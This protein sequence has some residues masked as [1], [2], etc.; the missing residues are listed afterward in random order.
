MVHTVNCCVQLKRSLLYLSPSAV[1][2]NR[3]GHM[4]IFLA[5]SIL[6][7]NM[8]WKIIGGEGKISLMW[9]GDEEIMEKKMHR[10]KHN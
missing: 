5:A 4:D 1:E 3:E 10:Y 9:K 6:M 2:N 8:L 7:H